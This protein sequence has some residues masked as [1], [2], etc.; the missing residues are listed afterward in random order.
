MLDFNEI[1]NTIDQLENSNTTYD[2][3][4]KLADLYTVLQYHELQGNKTND[5]VV[6][7]LSDIL[8]AYTQYVKVKTEYKLNKTTKEAVIQSINGLNKEIIEFI[9]ILFSSSDMQE[10]REKLQKTISDLY[11]KYR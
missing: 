2:T 7:E 3:C 5:N 9:D 10:E 8:P 6:D 4:G 1:R 11:N